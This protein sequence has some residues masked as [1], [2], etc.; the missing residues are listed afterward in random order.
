MYKTVVSEIGSIARLLDECKGCAL[1]A[2]HVLRGEIFEE[3][4]E[5][6]AD[7]LAAPRIAR[8]VASCHKALSSMAA[9]IEAATGVEKISYEGEMGFEPNFEHSSVAVILTDVRAALDA[10]VS[11][12]MCAEKDLLEAL[13]ICGALEEHLARLK[14]EATGPTLDEMA[15][16]EEIALDDFADLL[17]KAMG[18]PLHELGVETSGTLASR[19]EEAA[20]DGDWNQWRIMEALAKD[21]YAPFFNIERDP[22]EP[23]AT[24]SDLIASAL[25]GDGGKSLAEVA[26]ES[27]GLR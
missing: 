18:R 2:E 20:H 27:A 13:S 25:P 1:S 3:L 6:A 15:A 22:F 8:G 9:K 16:D 5:G 10:L 24:K 26:V 17:E 12:F 19:V 7:A 11:D 23:I 21:R 14:E 4:D